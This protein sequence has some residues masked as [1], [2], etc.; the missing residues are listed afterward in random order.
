MPLVDLKNIYVNFGKEKILDNIS[1]NID[2][3]KIITLIGPNGAGKSTLARAILGLIKIS[4]GTILKKK[5][6]RISYIPQKICFNPNFPI[7][8]E[9]FMHL[10]INKHNKNIIHMLKQVHSE[11]LLKQSVHSLSCGEL[12]KILLARVLLTVPHLLV[13]DEPDHGLDMN[14]QIL[15]YQLINK[16]HR[17]LSCSIFMIS[18]NLHIVMAKTHEVIC[19]NRS[20]LCRGTPKMISDHPSFIKIFGNYYKQQYALYC[21]NHNDK[22][23]LI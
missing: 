23:S 2:Y 11:H 15:L 21:H 14:G 4:S 17:I 10:N 13:L 3:Q 18:H 20:I 12:Q 16:I 7:T 8:V 19:L 6:L 22:N 9:Q 5:N 1:F